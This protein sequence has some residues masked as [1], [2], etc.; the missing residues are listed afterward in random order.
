MIAFFFAF[1]NLSNKM[2]TGRDANQ[3]EQEKYAALAA[4]SKIDYPAYLRW[5]K[6]TC[7]RIMADKQVGDSPE[8]IL[9]VWDEHWKHG[10]SQEPEQKKMLR[11]AW[12]MLFKK[13]YPGAKP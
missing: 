2:S 4:G 10:E 11:A 5:I 9:L 8:L 1:T 6:T 3:L 7:R 12:K 13:A